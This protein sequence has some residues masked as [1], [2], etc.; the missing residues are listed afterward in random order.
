MS[1][2]MKQ[3]GDNGLGTESILSVFILQSVLQ[4]A[5]F[6]LPEAVLISP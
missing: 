2:F 5:S 3:S 4:N 6:C 1:Q